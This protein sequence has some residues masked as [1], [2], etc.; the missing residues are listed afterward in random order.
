[1]PLTAAPLIEY[2]HKTSRSIIIINVP[3]DINVIVMYA[4][5]LLSVQ[6]KLPNPSLYY[7]TCITIEVAHEK[8]S[9]SR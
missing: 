9:V 3:D 8:E 1:V 5:L 4:R 7:L 6:D 2:A